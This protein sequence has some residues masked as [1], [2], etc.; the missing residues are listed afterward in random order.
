ML[1]ITPTTIPNEKE[2]FDETTLQSKMARFLWQG[3]RKRIL[4]ATIFINRKLD[5]RI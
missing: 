5:E 3:F 4:I 1:E 2:V